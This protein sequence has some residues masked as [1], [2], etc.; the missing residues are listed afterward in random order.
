MESQPRRRAP[1]E[2]HLRLAARTR[3]L[4][5]CGSKRIA[6]AREGIDDQRGSVGPLVADFV[7]KVLL[8]W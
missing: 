2:A 6:S 7:A 4:A 3:L 8:H 1:P 5:P